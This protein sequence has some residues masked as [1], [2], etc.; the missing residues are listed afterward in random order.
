MPLHGCH[1]AKNFQH[2][3]ALIHENEVNANEISLVIEE[4]LDQQAGN[5]EQQ[6]VYVPDG[7]MS[8]GNVVDGNPENNFLNDAIESDNEEASDD[9]DDGENQ[10]TPKEQLI[11]YSLTLDVKGIAAHGFRPSI[12]GEGAVELTNKK[13]L[14]S[15]G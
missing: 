7:E 2:P 10:L 12:D 14:D 9:E 4:D 3:P 1:D 6:H 11:N 8:R 13:Q 5:E 15:H